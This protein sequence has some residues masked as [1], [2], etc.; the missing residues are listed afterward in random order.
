MSHRSHAET[1][2]RALLAIASVLVAYTGLDNAL[3]G[4]ATFGLQGPQDFFQ[5]AD[6]DAFAA[7]DSHVRFLGGVWLGVALALAGGAIWLRAFRPVIYAVGAITFV[8]G[9]ARFSGMGLSEMIERGLVAP[10]IAELALVPLLALGV[11]RLDAARAPV[12]LQATTAAA[13]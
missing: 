13:R 8:G 12:D 9:L 5:I 10:L 11:W 1:A 3:G 4:V 7:R 2:V 6:A